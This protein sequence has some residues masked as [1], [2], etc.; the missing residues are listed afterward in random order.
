MV[1]I[2]CCINCT[3]RNPGCHSSCEDYIKEKAEYKAEKEKIL[4]AKSEGAEAY[5]ARREG[6]IKLQR[7]RQWTK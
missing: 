6:F 5:L 3:K 7:S 1:K 4:K 2:E